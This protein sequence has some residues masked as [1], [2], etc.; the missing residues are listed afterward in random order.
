MFK[1]LDQFIQNKHKYALMFVWIIVIILV[2]ICV[3]MRFMCPNNIPLG[4]RHNGRDGV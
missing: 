4:W 1:Q 2:L 3:F